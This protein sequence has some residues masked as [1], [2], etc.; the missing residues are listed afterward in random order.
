MTPTSKEVLSKGGKAPGVEHVAAAD[1]LTPADRYAELFVAVQTSRLFPDSKTFVDC[2]PLAAPGEI[3]RRYRADHALPGFD[4]AQFVREHFA[5]EPVPE[6]HYVADPTL[7][8]V[9]HIDGLWDVLSRRPAGHPANGSLLP[10][11]HDYVVPGG[12]F[13]EMYYWDS[14]FTMLG[15]AESRRHDLLHSMA[16][17]FSFI[18]DTYGHIP[19]GNRSYYLSRS[20]P[21]V[22]ALMIDLFETHGVKPAIRYLPQLKREH[23]YWMEGAESLAPGNAYRHVVRLPD[24]G[25]LN[26]YW[27]D[28][29]TP[30]EEGYLED[31]TT[32]ASQRARPAAE[33]YRNLRAGA[34]SGWD[35]SSRWLADPNDLST[36]RTTAIL[37]VDLN[38]LL[39]KLEKQIEKLSRASGDAETADAFLAR[40]NARRAAIDRY[41]WS[42]AEGAFVDYD[43][44]LGEQRREL[45]AA[46][47]APLYVGLATP[48]QAHR[49]ARALESRLLAAGGIRTT[50]QKSP[51]QWDSSNGW[52][53]LQWMAVRGLIR[54]GER[55]LGLEI[56]HRWLATVSA[57]YERECKLVEKYALHADV[58]ATGGSGGEYPLQDGFGWTN[59]VIRKLLHEH[60]HHRAHRSKAGVMQP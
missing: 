48:E 60:P 13:S 6:S 49:T 18:I 55:T 14:Y 40:A 54:Y 45:S 57:L 33:V 51:Q 12:R 20:Q 32:A 37:P 29:D 39:Y 52:A 53:P 47:A 7:T 46:L 38:S 27:D 25:L 19:N 17:N 1:V 3:V 11:P 59:G 16:E 56:A 43:W 31:I 44:Q 36:I 58:G 21:P 35:F 34:A 41:L 8:L 10:L 15:L 2:V 26:R 4:L 9:A 42:D 23:A 22:F 24:G 5:A 30:R 50:E 28:R